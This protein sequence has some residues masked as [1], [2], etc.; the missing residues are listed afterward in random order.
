MRLQRLR[1]RSI[2]KATLRISWR[3]YPSVIKVLLANAARNTEF[4][5]R[6]TL[7]TVVLIF[8]NVKTFCTYQL[9][10]NGNC[11]AKRDS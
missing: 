6:A 1:M 7:G 11:T 3:E 10:A 9:I 8:I 5:G 4:S 2:S